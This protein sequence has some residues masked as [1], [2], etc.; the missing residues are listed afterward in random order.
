M[1]ALSPLNLKNL[2][3]H[4]WLHCHWTTFTSA[5]SSPISLGEFNIVLD[6]ER[7][8]SETALQNWSRLVVICSNWRV[9]VC[10]FGGTLL[11]V[12]WERVNKIRQISSTPCQKNLIWPSWKVVLK[13]WN[14]LSVFFCFVCVCVV[15]T[16]MPLNPFLFAVTDVFWSYF[17][18][19]VATLQ[20]VFHWR[21]W[22]H[23]FYWVS[24]LFN[25]NEQWWTLVFFSQTCFEDMVLQHTHSYRAAA[26]SAWSEGW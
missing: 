17:W 25:V 20:G 2:H 26:R 14:L 16:E 15:D 9:C 22:F 8:F 3:F 5:C 11:K 4:M 1:I 10:V 18:L 13:V 12:N 21:V 6:W 19:A 23:R 7:P 24:G